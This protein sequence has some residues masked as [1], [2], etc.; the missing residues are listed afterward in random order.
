[1][2]GDPGDEMP[3]E[4]SRRRP[5]PNSLLRP[6]IVLASLRHGNLRVTGLA[7]PQLAEERDVIRIFPEAYRAIK[8]VNVGVIDVMNEQAQP[9]KIAPAYS[10][11][12]RAAR[13]EPKNRLL[14][15]PSGVAPL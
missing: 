11:N 14:A 9:L 7:R 4:T 1:M 15:T 6:A 12:Q 13:L 8:A 5:A 10:P 2:A 3:Q